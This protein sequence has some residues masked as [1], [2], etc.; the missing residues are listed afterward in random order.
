V[1]GEKKNPHYYSADF[2]CVISRT[3]R[4]ISLLNRNENDHHNAYNLSRRVFAPRSTLTRLA[5]LVLLNAISHPPYTYNYDIIHSCSSAPLMS[6]T[7]RGS[8]CLHFIPKRW[9]YNNCARGSVPSRVSAR[10]RVH[11]QTFVFGVDTSARFEDRQKI[12]STFVPCSPT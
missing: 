1:T 9:L 4:I 11:E 8:A 2:D 5:L 3:P 10:K 6:F 12:S 7:I